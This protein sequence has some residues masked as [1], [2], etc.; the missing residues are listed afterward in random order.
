V[1]LSHRSGDAGK[2]FVSRLFKMYAEDFAG[3]SRSTDEYRDGVLRFI[4][5]HT[6]VAV[7]SSGRPRGR[8]TTP[9]IGA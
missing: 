9:T 5:D 6:G 7:D 2:I 3:R 4:A 8:S 1:E